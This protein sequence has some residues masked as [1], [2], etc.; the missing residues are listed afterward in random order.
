MR[1]PKSSL[2]K[3]EVL[4]STDDVQ[5]FFKVSKTTLQL[6]NHSLKPVRVKNKKFYLL[7][8]ILE[9][10]AELINNKAKK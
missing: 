3:K 4:L 10:S 2:I 6:F 5:Q 9:L 1:N 8:D 7:S